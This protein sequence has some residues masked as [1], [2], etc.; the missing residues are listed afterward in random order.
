MNANDF[1]CLLFSNDYIA[2]KA[3]HIPYSYNEWINLP[4]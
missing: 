1:I 3:G 4:V 2:D